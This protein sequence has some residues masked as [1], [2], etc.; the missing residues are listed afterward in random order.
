MTFRLV[1]TICHRKSKRKLSRTDIQNPKT[2]PRKEN[3]YYLRT[4]S[5]GNG[6]RLKVFALKAINYSVQNPYKILASLLRNETVHSITSTITVHIAALNVALMWWHILPHCAFHPQLF[7]NSSNPLNVSMRSWHTEISAR[8]EMNYGTVLYSWINTEAW[9]HTV[10]FNG[11]KEGYKPLT[12]PQHTP[13][14]DEGLQWRVPCKKYFTNRSSSLLLYVL[15]II[16]MS[17]SLKAL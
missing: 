14:N 11:G 1:Q 10:Q 7:P 15:L 6:G 13:L 17:S 3:W 2:C 9:V 8:Q 12:S 4:G 5:E 16:Y